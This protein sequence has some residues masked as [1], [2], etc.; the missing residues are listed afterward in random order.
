MLR[1]I[2]IVLI[3]LSL[4]SCT[5]H[6]IISLDEKGFKVTKEPKDKSNNKEEDDY[7]DYIY[8][9]NDK[10]D[11]DKYWFEKVLPEIRPNY[12]QGQQ[13]LEKYITDKVIDNKHNNNRNYRLYLYRRSN[14]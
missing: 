10:E 4:H 14:E 7:E 13:D 12:E 8:D 11:V 3:I 2:I 6:Y 5:V 9:P 1:C